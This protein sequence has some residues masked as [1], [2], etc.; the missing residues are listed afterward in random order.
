ME[1]DESNPAKTSSERRRRR[2]SSR[3]RSH[4]SKEKKPLAR[5]FLK[6]YKVELLG[7]LLLLLGGFLLVE[8][9]EIRATLYSKLGGLARAAGRFFSM[10]I[11][12]AQGI[13][14]SDFVGI[15][16]VL[17]GIFLLGIRIRARVIRRQS[18]LKTHDVCPECGGAMKR[19]PSKLSHQILSLLMYVRIKR[20]ACR[21]CPT[22]TT[23]WESKR[24]A[25]SWQ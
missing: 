7:A 5:T 3:S 2:S 6:K 11:R 13:E 21:K 12:G 16:L 24:T 25:R 18:E 10:L 20:Y 9:L 15:L 17:G 22:R 8:K 19:A 14:F 4:R 1:K 23:L